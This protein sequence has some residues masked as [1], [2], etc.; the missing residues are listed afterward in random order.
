MDFFSAYQAMWGQKTEVLTPRVLAVRQILH[1]GMHASLFPEDNK[2]KDVDQVQFCLNSLTA[3][4]VP[5]GTK[6][7]AS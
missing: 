5:A 2:W 7:P 1:N 6:T 3:I 4:R